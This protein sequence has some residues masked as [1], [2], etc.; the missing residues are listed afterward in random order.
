[1]KTLFSI[2]AIFFI[3]SA[4]AGSYVENLLKEVE[5]DSEYYSTTLNEESI[6]NYN[7]HVEELIEGAYK[8]RDSK[9]RDFD[10]F[11][12]KDLFEAYYDSAQALYLNGY[13]TS[14]NLNQWVMNYKQLM[15]YDFNQIDQ[16]HAN[17]SDAERIELRYR[18]IKAQIIDIHKK[19]IEAIKATVVGCAKEGDTVYNK[20]CCEGHVKLKLKV[21]DSSQLKC[22]L[23]G[24]SCTSNSTCCSGMCQ[25][26]NPDEAGVCVA[27]SYCTKI[28]NPNESCSEQDF[29][30][31]DSRC[32]DYDKLD[33]GYLSCKKASNSCSDS[34]EC[35]SGSCSAGKC[36][37]KVYCSQCKSLGSSVGDKEACCPGTLKMNG[38]CQLPIP[39]FIPTVKVNNKTLI[40]KIVLFIKGHIFISS[41][42]AAD[43]LVGGLTQEQIQSLAAQ[44]SSCSAWDTRGDSTN[45]A[46][47]RAS[48]QQQR[49]AYITQNQLSESAQSSETTESESTQES[50]TSSTTNSSSSNRAELS[51][52]QKIILNQMA[53]NCRKRVDENLQDCLE[54]VNEKEVEFLASNA[55]TSEIETSDL[56]IDEKT[57]YMT[58][59]Q[60]PG[61][62]SK[63]YSD[64]KQ[65]SFNSFNDSWK[66]ASDAEKNA[67]LFL[68]AF[69]YVFSHKGTQ[70]YWEDS[71]KGNI[72]TRARTAAIDFRKNR[73]ALLMK[74][75]DIDKKMF[76]KCVPIYG[77]ENFDE[78]KQA[79]FNQNCSTQAALLASQKAK[80]ESESGVDT[81]NLKEIEEGGIGISH[82]QLLIEW[83]EL[84]AESQL[85]RFE[86]NADLEEDIEELSEYINNENYIKV[87]MDQVIS[88]QIVPGS[89]AGDTFLL[90]KWGYKIKKGIVPSILGSAEKGYK[91]TSSTYNGDSHSMK[92]IWRYEEDDDTNSTAM[93]FDIRTKKKRTSI[94]SVFYGFDRYYIGP[95]FSKSN[96]SVP[97]CN[98]YGRATAC[99]KSAYE[100]DFSG[101]TN[102]ILDPTLPLFVDS[103][104]VALDV[105]DG[106]SLPYTDLI[107]Q[108]KDEGVAY[109]RSLVP[110]KSKKYGYWRAGKKFGAEP[111]LDQAIELG[112]FQPKQGQLT[113]KSVE[114]AY[115]AGVIKDAIIKG[116]K[117]YTQCKDLK[118]DCGASDVE[119]GA[120]GFGYLFE[121]ASDAA[122]FAEYVYEI[123]WK[124]SHIT[125]N[126]YMGYPLQAMGQYFSLV[127]YNMKLVGTTAISRYMKYAEAAGLYTADLKLRESDYQATATIKN[128]S[129][130]SVK[131][132]FESKE[133]GIYNVLANLNLSG[134]TNLEVYDRAVSDAVKSGNLSS[135]QMNTLANARNNAVRR[136][137]DI[138]KAEELESALA[139]SDKATQN[140]YAAKKSSLAKMN[141]PIASA[142]LSSFGTAGAGVSG[143]SD[144]AS[145]SSSSSG[146]GSSKSSKDDTADAAKTAAKMNPGLDYSGQ[147]YGDN[148]SAD[149]SGA[150]LGT[151]LNLFGDDSGQE[152]PKSNINYSKDSGLSGKQVS[153]MLSEF[154]KD[155]SL[156]GSDNDSIFGLVSKAYKRNY[157]LI[158]SRVESSDKSNKKDDKETSELKALLGE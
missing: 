102:Y 143:F 2:L 8:E 12:P 56:E 151:S 104:L 109:L 70:D 11:Y 23:G 67:E 103:S 42:N 29:V 75:Q 21:K 86:L 5:S 65:C 18:F 118:A 25:K 88:K 82:E 4:L 94:M 78:T 120:L 108:A 91:A 51:S 125:K 157:G 39:R 26:D 122:R 96:S 41:A 14:Q 145:L 80:A 44:E 127:N 156:R 38:K 27:P 61:I 28:R 150:A 64:L 93:I 133:N 142:G 50:T 43:T 153:N 49:Q 89:P 17:L 119:D 87:Y 24:K 116:A 71:G 47:C 40:D 130:D 113:I 83:L 128:G 3:Q 52:Q 58:T 79:A 77:L 107:N 115:D 95:K 35:C 146:S 37:E 112:Y 10:S 92:A 16:L 136:N 126:N 135:G 13:A 155:K 123:H 32:I 134:T 36:E 105:M 90:Y 129:N 110:K 33:S 45:A 138:A 131:A 22:Q 158:L 7:K 111:H 46:K 137:N 97:S 149:L 101:E 140:A 55:G 34:S 124:W 48:L 31:K 66:D 117:T 69:E 63:T 132:K 154:S 57:N 139:N 62:T 147:A 99:F 30:C 100:V 76:C 9:V 84:R 6:I 59:Y 54:A 73:T 148:F 114:K 141:S 152:V 98:V 121:S 1:M 60:I 20:K 106:T 15:N 144:L 81:E 72:F 19:Y 74:M 68:R 85:A 53:L